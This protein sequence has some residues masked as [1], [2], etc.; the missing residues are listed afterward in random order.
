MRAL[1]ALEGT[2]FRGFQR[3]R[4]SP[5]GQAASNAASNVRT[6]A[7]LAALRKDMRE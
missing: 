2:G 6:H 5:S 3:L 1:Q 7:L 4:E